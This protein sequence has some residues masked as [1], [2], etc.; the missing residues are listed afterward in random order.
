[1]NQTSI[2]KNATTDSFYSQLLA[3]MATEG[4]ESNDLLP[5]RL[6]MSILNITNDSYV[7]RMF[8][9]YTVNGGGKSKLLS[10]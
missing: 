8:N 3:L 6:H 1:M 7:E 5:F 2:F 10:V 4:T 9:S